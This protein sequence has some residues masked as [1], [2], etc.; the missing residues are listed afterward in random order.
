MKVTSRMPTR[1]AYATARW[2]SSLGPQD[3]R[4]CDPITRVPRVHPHSQAVSLRAPL[5]LGRISRLTINSR[6]GNT[7]ACQDQSA[8]NS[9]SLRAPPHAQKDSCDSAPT[10]SGCIPHSWPSNLHPRSANWRSWTTRCSG[11][12]PSGQDH[13]ARKAFHRSVS[14]G[15]GSGFGRDQ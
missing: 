14:L 8:D 10:R 9:E 6:A 4:S 13:P 11:P 12:C 7:A 2:R 1:G 3:E 5:H 15:R